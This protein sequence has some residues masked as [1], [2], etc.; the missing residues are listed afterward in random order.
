MSA[1]PVQRGA[2]A[3]AALMVVALIAI[4][5]TLLAR[6]ALDRTMTSRMVLHA[7]RRRSAELAALMTEASRPSPRTVPTGLLSLPSSGA[8][9]IVA[10]P[11]V[12]QLHS[13]DW[14][15][16]RRTFT[17]LRCG[18][19]SAAS[20]DAAA[21]SFPSVIARMTCA[22]LPSGLT[23][24][25]ML[26]ANLTTVSPI[27]L[28]TPSGTLIVAVAGTV[29]IGA[30]LHV[31]GTLTIAAAGDIRIT[32]VE[33]DDDAS[34]VLN[35]RTG[36]VRIETPPERS[37]LCESRER[38]PLRIR[39]EGRRVAV[40]S[41]ERGGTRGCDIAPAGGRWISQKLVG[42]FFDYAGDAS[43]G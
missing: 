22:R 40:G 21:R 1:S 35:S 4:S 42:A 33:G 14:S 43:T 13:L 7:A 17:A 9:V 36:D 6:L 32:N 31:S 2:V 20:V 25:H 29:D 16:A 5:C 34:L 39:L 26:N 28:G 12:R 38:A 3:V 15:A 37:S 10:G 8:A 41:D 19:A 24:S 27:S 30:A 18:S 23:G 11:P